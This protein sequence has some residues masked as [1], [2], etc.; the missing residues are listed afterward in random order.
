MSVSACVSV[1]VTSAQSSRTHTHTCAVRSLSTAFFVGVYG[2]WALL[3][4][5]VIY[6][7]EV[8]FALAAKR[9]STRIHDALLYRV[10]GAP[11]SWFDVTPIGYSWLASGGE[12]TR[13]AAVDSL[14]VWCSRCCCWQA[15]H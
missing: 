14:S 8:V 15:H 12:G 3:A 6:A 9:A 7:K 11:M 13:C 2:G 4:A 1:I 10:I 5:V